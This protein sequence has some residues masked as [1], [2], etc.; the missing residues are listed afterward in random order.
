[1]DVSSFSCMHDNWIL[2]TCGEIT[3]Y[4]DY[5]IVTIKRI[6]Y[7]EY[8]FPKTDP[9]NGQFGVTCYTGGALFTFANHFRSM[10]SMDY[11]LTYIGR[12]RPQY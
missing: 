10:Y 8:R 3:S 12:F 5:K 7:H 1:M 6:E 4:G 2:K 11:L 9:R